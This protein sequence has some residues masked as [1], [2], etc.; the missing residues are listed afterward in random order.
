MIFSFVWD[1]GGRVVD[2]GQRQRAEAGRETD[3]GH[4]ET[5]STT[6]TV[7]LHTS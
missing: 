3:N 1:F 7:I 6:T 2:Y 5:T 4:G